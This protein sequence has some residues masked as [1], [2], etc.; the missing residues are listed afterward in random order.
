MTETNHAPLPFT[1]SRR[2]L[3][4]QWVCLLK[5]SVLHSHT[6]VL[7]STQSQTVP[8]KTNCSTMTQFLLQ[9]VG[10]K[11]YEWVLRPRQRQ[12]ERQPHFV[13]LSQQPSKS[14]GQH[15]FKCEV[16]HSVLCMCTPGSPR[17]FFSAP[18]PHW[19]QVQVP[20]K[21]R[22]EN[23]NKVLLWFLFFALHQHHSA[24]LL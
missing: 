20:Q 6:L 12:H 7:P 23:K 9:P 18:R 3:L 8:D 4:H 10:S 1:S 21:H 14:T 16:I 17:C 24:T 22:Q 15:V 19:A 11:R 2:L 5:F 13:V